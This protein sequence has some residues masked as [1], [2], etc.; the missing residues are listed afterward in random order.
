MK[1]QI[2]RKLA[3]HGL[4]RINTVKMAS[5]LIFEGCKLF[6]AVIHTTGCLYSSLSKESACNAGE[7][8]QFLGWEDPL[9]KEMIT[10]STI[11]TWRIPWTEEPGSYSPWDRKS[12]TQ[13][14][15]QTTTMHI[16]VIGEKSVH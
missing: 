8:V 4:G 6:K 7:R 9:E 1:A 16:I 10:H 2:N 13:L 5:P 11:L 3:F 12:R 15:D 14:N